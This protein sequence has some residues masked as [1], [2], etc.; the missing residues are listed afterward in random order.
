MSRFLNRP[1]LEVDFL[2]PTEME[3]DVQGSSIQGGRNSLGE[4]QNIDMSGGGRVTGAYENCF[5]HS[6][7]QHEYVNWLG[8]YLNGGMRYINVPI[9]SD[10]AG[11]FP[12]INGRMTPIA[13]G[14]PH[15][16][17]AMFGDGVGYSQATVYG[18]IRQNRPLNSG[19][20]RLQVYGAARPLRWSD[21][22]SIYHPTKGWRAYRYWQVISRN[23]ATNPTYD[24]AIS[25]PLR[26]AVSSGDRVEFA[27]PRFVAKFPS[28]FTLPWRVTAPWFGSPTI[29]FVEA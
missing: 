18:I 20:L 29:P 10:F 26:E 5:V 3:F 22:F 12:I 19:T 23:D 17:G 15:S 24:L 8:A 27:R 13:K 7:E 11:P 14:I 2:K 21:W 1:V 6:A 25:P 16:D 28:E 4:T 9:L